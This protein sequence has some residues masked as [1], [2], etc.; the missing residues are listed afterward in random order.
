MSHQTTDQSYKVLARAYRPQSF[1]EMVGQ[2]V[3]VRT[4]TNAIESGRLPHAYVLTGI[5][6]VGKTT[7]ARLLAKALNCV[8]EDGK[9]GPTTSPCGKCENCVAITHDNHVDV[10][11]MDA[12]SRTGVDDI[13]EL[14]DGVQYKATQ[15]RFKIYIIDEVHMLSKNA[16]NALLKTLEEP[17]AHVKFIFATTEIRKVPVTI[18]SRCQ[19]FDLR[20]VDQET[21]EKHFLNVAR[22]EKVEI[23]QEALS[24]I[25]RAADGSVRDGMSLLEQAL[26]INGAGEITGEVV[27]SMLGLVDRTVLFDLFDY[28]MQ[29]DVP[30]SLE[31]LHQMHRDGAEIKSVLTDLLDLVHWMSVL[32]TAPGRENDLA[33]SKECVARGR[34]MAQ[35]LSVPVFTRTWQILLKGLEEISVAHTPL[36]GAEMV[37]LRLCYAARMPTPDQLI[38]CLK[39]ENG[40]PAKPVASMPV[41]DVEKD[42][43][44]QNTIVDEKKGGGSETGNAKPETFEDVVDL[45]MAK[46]EVLLHA[47]LKSDVHLVSFAPKEIKLRLAKEASGDLPKKLSTHLSEWTGEKWIVAKSSEKGAST[48]FEQEEEQQKQDKENAAQD[49]SIKAV[50]EAFPD[51]QIKEVRQA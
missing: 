14:I 37:L 16:F 6:G 17:P 25:A 9:G 43:Q 23:A 30:K 47:A 32:A 46:G 12:A 34:E 44:V 38:S 50:L 19:R 45:C 24:L 5:R 15:S 33:Y 39:E 21:L 35:K 29:G 20:R 28:L 51:A 41:A 26:T 36:A 10:L 18:L 22:K 2:D 42:I 8:G 40:V 48:L 3:L 11:E 49:P 4:L 27:R 7:T 1:D 13:R 31:I